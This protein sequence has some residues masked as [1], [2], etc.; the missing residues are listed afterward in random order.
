MIDIL[1][2][3]EPEEAY[4]VPIKERLGLDNTRKGKAVLMVRETV[5]ID[6]GKFTIQVQNTHGKATATCDVNILGNAACSCLHVIQ[7]V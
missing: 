4:V 2:V 3:A 5:R 7:F 6:H 1:K